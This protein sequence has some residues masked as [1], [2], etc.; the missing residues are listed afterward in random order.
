MAITKINNNTL[1]AVTELPA[2]IATG[3]VLQV[4]STTKTDA[5]SASIG[6]GDETEVT[7]LTLSITPSSTSSKIFVIANISSVADGYWQYFNIKRDSTQIGIGDQHGSNRQRRA[8]GGNRGTTVD[9]IMA[10]SCS[11]LDTPSSTSALDYQVVIANGAGSTGTHY[12]NQNPSSDITSR[13]SFASTITAYE[14]AG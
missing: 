4:V 6:G 14:I 8:T 12:V 2:A 1:S 5:W 7:N 3:K 11:V 13:A 10:T 9:G